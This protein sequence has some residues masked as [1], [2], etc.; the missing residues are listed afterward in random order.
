MNLCFSIPGEPV[1]QGRPRFSNRGNFIKAYDPDKSRNYKAFVKVLVI[2]AMKKQ[3]C[4]LSE[5]PLEVAI[6]AY[7]GI[8]TSKPKKFKQQALEGLQKPTKKPDVDNVA[9][10]IL[11][12]ITGIAYQDDKQIVKL[13]V[14]KIY[15]ETPKVEVQIK[16]AK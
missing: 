2:D 8:P 4:T 10:I 7:V 5:L 15:S 6:I 11:D 9:K 3:G 1:A 14:S 12:S 13:S 16:D